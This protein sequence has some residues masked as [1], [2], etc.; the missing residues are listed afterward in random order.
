MR[1]LLRRLQLQPRP[2]PGAD[3]ED[4]GGGDEHR[5]H[6]HVLQLQPRRPPPYEEGRHDGGELRHGRA[7][8]VHDELH[9]SGVHERAHGRQLQPGAGVVGCCSVGSVPGVSFRRVVD[10]SLSRSR[11]GSTVRSPSTPDW[12]CPWP[13]HGQCHTNTR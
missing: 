5:G 13:F 2:P 11:H 1:P 6:G 4:E 9:G 7:R 3:S 8:H 10:E 12:S